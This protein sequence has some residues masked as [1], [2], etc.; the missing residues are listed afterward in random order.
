MN[1]KRISYNLIYF[2]F[3]FVIGCTDNDQKPKIDITFSETSFSLEEGFKRKSYSVVLEK[4]VSS[5]TVVKLRVSGI[6]ILGDDYEIVPAPINGILSLE[7]LPNQ[8]STDFLIS[9]NIDQADELAETIVLSFDELP[10]DFSAGEE[11]TVTI[12]NNT[13]GN[14]LVG[15][16][17]LDGTAN[18]T[19]PNENHGTVF[20]A[21]SAPDHKN[22]AGH[23]LLFDGTDDYVSIPNSYELNFPDNSDFSISLWASPASAQPQPSNQ[24]FDIVRKWLGNAEGYPFSISYTNSQSSV[25]NRFFMARYDGSSCSNVASISSN[26]ITGDTYYH[27]VM[28][29]VGTELK[30]YVD[31]ELI[32]Q[33]T[34]TTISS[35]CLATNTSHITVG[36]RG[37]LV[38][39]YKGLV[40]DLRFYN[41]ALTE[42]E[43]DKLFAI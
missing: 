3:L 38:R 17:L 23:A 41:R 30:L 33:G 19:S 37:Q 13:L 11:L 29:K 25:P 40:D 2:V 36:C 22:F 18:D 7:I 28:V 4:T 34:D 5:L 26:V 27:V 21:T 35:N 43:I 8:T 1:T 31:G 12:N 15:E 10:T 39:F 14:G 20:S 16:Y 6:A 32:S 9:T 42:G 24:I